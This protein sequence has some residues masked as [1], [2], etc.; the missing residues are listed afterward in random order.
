M[1]GHF[2][3]LLPSGKD[4]R[5]LVAQSTEQSVRVWPVLKTKGSEERQLSRLCSPSEHFHVSETFMSLIYKGKK[6]SQDAGPANAA[7]SPKQ[8]SAC[9]GSHMP[10]ARSHR[11]LLPG[12]QGAGGREGAR[13]SSA[14]H[15]PQALGKSL[16][17][18]GLQVLPKDTVMA[19]APTLQGS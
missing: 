7:G 1:L 11:V 3:Q 10:A 2:T 5:V 17:P 6:T 13:S 16:H 19:G 15:L 18:T 14:T 8:W 12:R 4:A 9:G